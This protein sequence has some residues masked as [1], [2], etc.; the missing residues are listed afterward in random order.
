[1]PLDPLGGI[2]IAEGSPVA[3]WLMQALPFVAIGVLFYV[4]LIKPERKKQQDQKDM[5]ASVRK[6]DRVVTVGGI[7]GIVTNVHRD[8][9]EITINVD[10]STGTKIRVTMAAISRVDRQDGKSEAT[11][12]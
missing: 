10:E 2:L 11:K 9:D 1:M 3:P 4:M 7:K 8:N 12:K 6:N 5:L